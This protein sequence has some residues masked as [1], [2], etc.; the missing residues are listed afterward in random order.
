MSPET[1]R[2]YTPKFC[3]HFPL[4]DSSNCK[5]GNPDMDQAVLDSRAQDQQLIDEQVVERVLAGDTSLFE[6]IMRR[7]NQ[8]LYR[9][10]RAITRSDSEAEDVLQDA[11]VRAF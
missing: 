11:Y 1:G 3:N 9:A 10:A 5:A 8:R 4:P 7:Y 2:G 6:V